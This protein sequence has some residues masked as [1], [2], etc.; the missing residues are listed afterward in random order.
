MPDDKIEMPGWVKDEIQNWNAQY[1]DRLGDDFM[2]MGETFAYD[3]RT[4]AYSNHD[5]TKWFTHEQVVGLMR[6]SRFTRP[7]ETPEPTNDKGV[8]EYL[9]RKGREAADG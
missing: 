1:V 7:T 3:P 8:V 5:G 6:G 4:Q 2:Y 9:A